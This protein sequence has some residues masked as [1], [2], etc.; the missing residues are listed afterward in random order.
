MNERWNGELAKKSILYI[1]EKIDLKRKKESQGYYKLVVINYTSNIYLIKIEQ[2]FICQLI[3]IYIYI[4]LI[5]MRK[6]RLFIKYNNKSNVVFSLSVFFFSTSS[7]S[8]IIIELIRFLAVANSNLHY[9]FYLF[10]P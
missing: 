1:K 10:I 8:S 4:L 7:A 3:Y 2:N 9:Y 5:C 6:M